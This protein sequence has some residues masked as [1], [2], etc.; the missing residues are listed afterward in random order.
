MGWLDSIIS[1]FH[2]CSYYRRIP[3]S[4]CFRTILSRVLLTI[5]LV[6]THGSPLRFHIPVTLGCLGWNDWSPIP[7]SQICQLFTAELSIIHT[8][9]IPQNHKSNSASSKHL[10][11]ELSMSVTCPQPSPNSEMCTA[12]ATGFLSKVCVAVLH[13]HPSIP[14]GHPPRPTMSGACWVSFF[15]ESSP[16]ARQLPFF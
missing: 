16:C 14:E 7:N 10:R 3:A 6:I 4:A 13:L 12:H 8:F 11:D 2:P 5:S 1:Q 9:L 15:L